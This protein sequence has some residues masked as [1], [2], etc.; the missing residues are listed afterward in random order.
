[1]RWTPRKN[2]AKYLKLITPLIMTPQ[3]A[4]MFNLGFAQKSL[5]VLYDYG[6][7]TTMF[8]ALADVEDT[9]AL[10]AYEQEV[11]EELDRLYAE[12]EK[13]LNKTF[14][15]RILLPAVEEAEK[16]MTPEEAVLYTLGRQA[17]VFRFA[18]GILRETIEM[19]LNLTEEPDAA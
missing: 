18:G 15:S 13:I 17:V 7:F 5:E 4:R 16:T 9:E 1:M 6:V 8:P 2:C 19:M 3:L 14:L 11:A 12:G 10:K